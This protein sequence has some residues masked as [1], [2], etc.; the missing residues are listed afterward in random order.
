[1]LCIFVLRDVFESLT[2]CL[3]LWLSSLLDC[4]NFCV[5]FHSLKNLLLSSSIASR[6]IAIYQDPWTYFLDRSYRNF[7]PL[8]LFGICLDSFST[9]SRSIEKGSAWL[10]A[11]RSI[12]VFFPPTNSWQHLDR[13]IC[14]ELVLDRSWQILDPTFS[15]NSFNMKIRFISLILSRLICVFSPSKHFL[16]FLNLKPVRIS[17]LKS[18]CMMLCMLLWMTLCMT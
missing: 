8:K 18:Y 9:D 2:C 16:L 4:I 14:R 5:F 6:Q 3:V 1:M 17:A 13:F 11:V 7:D 15:L 10:I 12:E